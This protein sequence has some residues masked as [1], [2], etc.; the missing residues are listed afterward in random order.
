MNLACRC[1]VA[2]CAIAT[3][4]AAFPTLAQGRPQVDLQCEAIAAGPRL[5]CRVRLA[6]R[7]GAPIDGAAVTLGATM[8]SMP[9]VHAVVP[10]ATRPT[11]IPGEYRG[12]LDLEMSGVWAIQVDIAG[13]LRDRVVRTLR[14]EEC[15]STPRCPAL[16]AKR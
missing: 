13:P 8:P 10:A 5:D 4:G 1:A 2:A 14:A 7:A 6:T 15:T 11:G 9:M 16:P 12:A 3:T